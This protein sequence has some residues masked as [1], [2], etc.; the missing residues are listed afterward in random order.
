MPIPP[1]VT[2][3]TWY[4]HRQE[5]AICRCSQRFFES[6]G[7]PVTKRILADEQRLSA[8]DVQDLVHKV[9]EIWVARGAK[10]ARFD[11]LEAPPGNQ[12]LLNLILAPSGNLRAPAVLVGERLVVGFH[13]DAY[14]QIFG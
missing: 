5:C 4:Y 13:E 9:K 6:R 11:M 12:A 8:E 1:R 2:D 14:Q 7:L 3:I 10:I